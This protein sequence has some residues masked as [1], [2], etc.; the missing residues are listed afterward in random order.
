[1]ADPVTVPPVSP[2]G[3]IFMHRR[4]L[5]QTYS[6][7]AFRVVWGSSACLVAWC[8]GSGR[9]PERLRGQGC[10]PGEAGDDAGALEQPAEV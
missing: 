9:S 8:C 5:S 1:M 10:E 2:P 7:A 6:F 3:R 4:A